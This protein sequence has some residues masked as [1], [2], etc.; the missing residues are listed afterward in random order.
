MHPQTPSTLLLPTTNPISLPPPSDA[1]LPPPPPPPPFHKTLGNSKTKPNPQREGIHSKIHSPP[2]SPLLPFSIASPP[3]NCFS[4]RNHPANAPPRSQNPQKPNWPKHP[5]C[6]LPIHF[7]LAVPSSRAPS[8]R[9]RFEFAPNPN[10]ISF[11]PSNLPTSSYTKSYT[12]STIPF[13]LAGFYFTNGNFTF[14]HPS[15]P[16]PPKP[17]PFAS[18][19]PHEVVA[20]LSPPTPFAPSPSPF[21]PKRSRMVRNGSKWFQTVPNWFKAMFNHVCTHTPF[22]PSHH[23]F[24]PTPLP[25]LP[26]SSS[27]SLLPI[28]HTATPSSRP[29]ATSASASSTPAPPATSP[30]PFLDGS[31][32]DWRPFRPFAHPTPRKFKVPTHP[33]QNDALP[34]VLQSEK[35]LISPQPRQLRASNHH[36]SIEDLIS[37]RERA[38]P[39][40]TEIGLSDS[41]ELRSTAR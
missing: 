20:P 35:S 39:W 7:A 10:L 40:N 17:L 31:P 28:W 8:P 2:F 37:R 1:K 24:P 27:P 34:K 6:T 18:A 29:S 19:P 11:A 5:F 9:A 14:L 41:V 22:S 13:E 4:K 3:P 16:L 33:S 21:L 38:A 26:I 25:P 30:N 12:I 15:S 23:L 36:H 32:V